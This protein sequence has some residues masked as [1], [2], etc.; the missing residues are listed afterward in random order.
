MSRI[1]TKPSAFA[2]WSPSW[3]SRQ[4]RQSS[5]SENP[6]RRDTG[7]A[8]TDELSDRR[9]DEPGRV[10][11][12]VAAA[13]PINE[14]D[15]ICT[16]LLTP[17]RETR[18]FR[19]CAKPGAPILLHLR[20]DRVVSGGDRSRSWRVREDV[21]LRDAGR[22]DDRERVPERALRLGRE[23]DDR[24]GGEVVVGERLEPAEVRRG[25]VT[26]RHVAQH[27]VVARLERNVKVP[28][29]VRCFTQR[30]HE[31]GVDMVDLDRREAEPLEPRH[32]ADLAHQS[33]QRITGRAV[34]VAPEVDAR[35]DDLLVSVC[36]A[37]P[38]L[39]E[40]CDRRPTARRAAD[41]RDHAEVAREAAAVLELD[42]RAHAVETGISLNAA[43]RTHVPGHEGRRLL[44]RPGDDGYVGRQTRK[45]VAGEV[46]RAARD[47]DARVRA[48]HACSGLARFPDCFVRDATRID[49]GNI[50]T[51]FWGLLEVTVREQALAD[52]LRIRVG[53]L[54]AEKTDRERRHGHGCYWRNSPAIRSV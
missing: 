21:D 34:S 7:P 23:T 40:H 20:R 13:G 44:A 2:T 3:T 31:L 48:R 25:A 36:D 27:P 17:A 16:D 42:E 54:A 8:D 18:R 4:K 46:R 52:F 35:E 33:R 43:D 32:G 41:E 19:R 38:D 51:G 6:L 5:G 39:V 37:P 47:V 22:P 1:A 15:V 24:V 26:A 29:D 45:G 53:D 50:G 28:A 14:D 30:R 9:L 11:V 49:D 12:P 10:I